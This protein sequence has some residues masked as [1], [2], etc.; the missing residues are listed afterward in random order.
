[1]VLL[2]S[3]IRRNVRM[4]YQRNLGTPSWDFAEIL[5]E[6]NPRENPVWNTTFHFLWGRPHGLVRSSTHGCE[7]SEYRPV[8]G[9][10]VCS[11]WP[12][13]RGFQKSGEMLGWGTQET[14]VPHPGILL[15]FCMSEI[16]V[17]ILSGTRL[18]IFCGG[19]HM[20]WSE[21]RLMDAKVLN[22]AL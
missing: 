16:L 18:F 15:R 1:M 11:F 10:G 3:E 6:R 5:H 20:D 9:S 8:S 7:S 12:S 19:G 13:S 21:A 17:K 14:W 22:T 4:G 2:W